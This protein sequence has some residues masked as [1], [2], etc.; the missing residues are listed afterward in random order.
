MFSM[1]HWD[2]HLVGN[3]AWIGFGEFPGGEMLFWVYQILAVVLLAAASMTALQDAQATEWRDVAIGE[4][5]EV[6]VYRDPRGTFT[7]SV[8]ITFI[9]AVIIMFLVRGKTT[10]AVPFYGVGVFM[11]IMVMGLAVRNH[12]A[13]HLFW[14]DADIGELGATCSILWLPVFVGQIVGK[15]QKA[16][17]WC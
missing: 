12:I 6:I 5:P 4:I 10:Q 9:A 17:G 7:R 11:P 2:E 15:W 3:L 16:A 8:T 14:S 13:Q 1:A